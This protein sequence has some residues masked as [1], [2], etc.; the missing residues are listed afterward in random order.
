MLLWAAL[1]PPFFLNTT[2][3]CSCPHPPPWGQVFQAPSQRQGVGP[4]TEAKPSGLNFFASDCLGHMHATQ[5][6]W[7]THEQKSPGEVLAKVFW[8]L[9]DIRKRRSFF[10]P[11]ETVVR[12]QCLEVTQSSW[13]HEE[14]RSGGTGR[15]LRSADS[16][17]QEWGSWHQW[18]GSI[19]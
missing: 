3:I 7:M 10:L 8:I 9:R 5:F 13:D 18:V 6:W 16:W 4:H 12:V 2:T 1:C 14:S 11:F 15:K 19:S 17:I